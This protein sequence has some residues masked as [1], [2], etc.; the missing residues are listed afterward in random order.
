MAVP[1]HNE[2][3]Y[4]PETLAALARAG[5]FLAGKGGRLIE[6]LVVD[7]GSTDRTAQVAAASGARVIHEPEHNIAVVRNRGGEAARGE[8]I[9]FVDADTLVPETFLWRIHQVTADPALLGGAVDTA[10]RPDG[11]IL[12]GYLGLYRLLGRVTGMA[13]GAAQFYR[14]DVFRTLG[15]YA[16]GFSWERTLTC[17]GG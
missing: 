10:Y 14:R 2:E 4:L 5:E 3:K 6:I 7:N 12:K 1:A 9:V 11:F 16:D 13:Q 15:G 8:V 17:F